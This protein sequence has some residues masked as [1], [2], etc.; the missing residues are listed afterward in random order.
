MTVKHGFPGELCFT[1]SCGQGDKDL[2]SDFRFRDICIDET[3]APLFQDRIL[4]SVQFW[5]IT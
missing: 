3:Q 1:H 5:E 4:P 2:R